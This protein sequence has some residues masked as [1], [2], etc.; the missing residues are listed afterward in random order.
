MPEYSQGKIY[1]LVDSDDICLYVGST[2]QSLDLRLYGHKYA[3]VYGVNLPLYRYIRSLGE[4][5]WVGIS[6]HLVCE[7]PCNTLDELRQIE[8]GYI[9]LLKPICNRV[10]AGRDSKQYYIDNK[11][12]IR[13]FYQDHKTRL[14]DY[15]KQYNL[16]HADHIRDYMRHYYKLKRL[17]AN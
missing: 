10:I 5:G 16:A 12:R 9:R 2:V 13:Q 6:I 4:N 8:G 1:K 3:Y 7:A 17:D 14:I 11:D 15:Q